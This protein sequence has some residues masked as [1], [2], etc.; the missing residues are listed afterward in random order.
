MDSTF[1][2]RKFHSAAAEIPEKIL[3]NNGLKLSVEIVWE[4][5]ALK[6]YNPEWSG[7]PQSPLDAE[8]RIFF[9][10]WINDKSISERKIYYNIHALKLRTLKGYTITSRNF[11]QDFRKEFVKYQ[12]EWP[13][14]S[15]NYGPLTLMEGWVALKED[16]IEKDIHELAQRFLKI[17]PIIDNV[18]KQYKK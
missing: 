5:V 2:L 15:V 4:S 6:V 18:L 8:G 9:S 13:N 11:A 17:S 12:K 14:V 16:D 7:N 1:Y 10:V 3:S